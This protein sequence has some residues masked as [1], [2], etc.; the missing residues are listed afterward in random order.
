MGFGKA[1]KKIKICLLI[2]SLGGGGAERIAY[3]ILC[4][5]DP[6]KFDKHL[7]L[8]EKK[9]GY[10]NRFPLAFLKDRNVRDMLLIHSWY[11]KVTESRLAKILGNRFVNM[12]RRIVSAAY[13]ISNPWYY[14][15]QI[16]WTVGKEAGIRYFLTLIVTIVGEEA[17]LLYRKGK[18]S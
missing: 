17:V 6:E 14:G 10:L 2:A 8:F 9:G 1:D 5:L 4:R 7:I 12:G 13:N 3:Y 15:R 16:I 11:K 18:K